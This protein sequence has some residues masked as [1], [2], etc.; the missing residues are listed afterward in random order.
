MGGKYMLGIPK[1]FREEAGIK[2]GDNIVVTLEKD[3]EERIVNAPGDFA[4]ELSEINLR[5]A[6]DD[7]SYTHRKEH[8]RAI[9]EAKSPEPRQSVSTQTRDRP[10]YETDRP[11]ISAIGSCRK[12]RYDLREKAAKFRCSRAPSYG[13][14]A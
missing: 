2:A 6:F 12:E 11:Q 1:A 7:M 14:Q 3:V 13:R 4:A 9:E 5:D 10:G 8:V